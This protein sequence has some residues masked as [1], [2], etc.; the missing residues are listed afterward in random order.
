[1]VGG[2]GH[3][4]GSILGRQSEITA[5][6]AWV[7]SGPLGPS[8]FLQLLL[9]PGVPCDMAAPLQ[10]PPPSSQGLLCVFCSAS[11]LFL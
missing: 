4:L 8:C 3:G 9:A 6:A 2:V 10:A 1:M 7:P 11:L 5:S